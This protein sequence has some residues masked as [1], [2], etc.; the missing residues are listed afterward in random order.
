MAGAKNIP[1][2]LL[3]FLLFVAGRAMSQ[4][5]ELIL[6]A[7]MLNGYWMVTLKTDPVTGD[8]LIRR[9]Q[10]DNCCENLDVEDYRRLFNA[11]LTVKMTLWH[12]TTLL[13]LKPVAAEL[14]SRWYK[15][16]AIS[17]RFEA[18]ADSVSLNVF[19]A[20]EGLPLI[21]KVT[22]ICAEHRALMQFEGRGDTTIVLK[23]LKTEEN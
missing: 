10:N 5:N 1:R 14:N 11:L 16:T 2:L 19:F 18:C 22:S 13:Y 12:D 17:Q 23:P 4:N 20:S 7:E 9:H 15:A 3:L 8:E 6:K 21:F